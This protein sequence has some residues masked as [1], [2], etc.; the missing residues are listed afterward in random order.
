L[1]LGDAEDVGHP[2]RLPG[3]TAFEHDDAFDEA[4]AAVADFGELEALVL[5][6]VP[7]GAGEPWNGGS[8]EDG[9]FDFRRLELAGLGLTA[10]LAVGVVRALRDQVGRA[11]GHDED[12]YEDEGQPAGFGQPLTEAAESLPD[13]FPPRELRQSRLTAAAAL[14]TL[15]DRL[16]LS[17]ARLLQSSQLLGAL[18]GHLRRRL[19]AIRVPLRRRTRPLAQAADVPCLRE[20]QHGEEGQPD[21]R[22]QASEGADFLDQL[23]VGARG[24][25][26]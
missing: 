7:E 23:Q 12:H 22:S 4:G 26:S 25:S 21:K 3:V 18:R 13:P 16:L 11:A 5:D 15:L 1:H 24:Y 10:S 19:L 9:D 6:F 2:V 17:R 14:L 8:V 20:R